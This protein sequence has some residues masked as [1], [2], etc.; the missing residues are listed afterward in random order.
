MLVPAVGPSLRLVLAWP[1]ALV[2]ALTGVTLPPPAVTVKFTVVPAWGLLLPSRTSTTRGWLNVVFTVP[3]WLSPLALVM[4]NPAVTVRVAVA[5]VSPLAAAV[6]VAV[7][8][9]WA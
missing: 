9:W 6:R 1:L 8:R 5:L 7:P 2:T 4:V 3:L